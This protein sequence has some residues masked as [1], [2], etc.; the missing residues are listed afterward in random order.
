M[1]KNPPLECSGHG[2]N[3]W[4]RRI[5][6]AT[7]QLSPCTTTTGPVL[8]SLWSTTK[9]V[10]TVRSLHTTTRQQLPLTT[11]K[12]RPSTAIRL[13]ACQL[14]SRDYDAMKI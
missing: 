1:V 11:A 7:G 14:S 8:L 10:N 5:P 3:P 6:Q 9:D 2:F 13:C 4:S 12:E